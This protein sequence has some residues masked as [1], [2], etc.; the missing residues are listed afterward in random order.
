MEINKATINKINT[1]S[2]IHLY[3]GFA[4]H[5]FL[6]TSIYEPVM[7]REEL[8]RPIGLIDLDLD[9]YSLERLLDL[10]ILHE[11]VS[12][13][14]M[15]LPEIT[16][17]QL[18]TVLNNKN[19]TDLTSIQQYG[20]KCGIYNIKDKYNLQLKFKCYDVLGPYLNRKADGPLETNVERAIHHIT[21]ISNST[22]GLFLK[23]LYDAHLEI[24]HKS[25]KLELM[26]NRIGRL[27]LID[28][29]MNKLNERLYRHSH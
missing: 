16:Q 26:G 19:P 24:I 23:D 5:I 15:E 12:K 8:A 27:K 13:R 10:Y 29:E 3:I 28:S 20:V 1:S 18:N 22:K 21:N 7:Y 14:F 2:L 25:R 9:E 17:K 6:D 4:I 11:K